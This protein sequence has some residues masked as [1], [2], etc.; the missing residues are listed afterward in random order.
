MTTSS[1]L[2]PTI[3]S[4]SI[5]PL[6]ASRLLSTTNP[7]PAQV[8][9]RAPPR[10]PRNSIRGRL[11]KWEEENPAPTFQVPTDDSPDTSVGN[12]ITKNTSELNFRLDVPQDED[13]RTPQ[14][15][16][17]DIIDLGS[18]GAVLQP[19][20]LVELRAST[21][22]LRLLAICLGL[23]NGHWHFYT[24]T[25][26]W[27]TTRDMRFG[28]VVRG[29]VQ[30][31]AELRAVIDAIPSTSSSTAVLNELQELNIGPSRD[32]AASLLRRMYA[33]QL[34]A[35][36]IHQSYVERLSRPHL[37]LGDGERLLSLREIADALLPSSLKRNQ[38]VFPPEALYAVYSVIEQDDVAFRS[39]D[40]TARVNEAFL[41]HFYSSRVQRSVYEVEEMVRNYFESKRS[42]SKSQTKTQANS[43]AQLDRFLKAA[44]EVID[45]TRKTRKWSPHG[46]IGTCSSEPSSG[47]SSSPIPA[48][49]SDAGMTIIEFMHHWAASGGF[50]PGSRCHAIGA[51]VLRALERYDDVL[52]DTTTGWTF[53]QEIGWIAPWDVAARHRLRIPGI[54]LDRHP[55]LPAPPVSQEQAKKLA[56]GEDRLAGLRQ[57]FARSSVFCIDSADT[58]DVDD[59]VSLEPGP[60]SG[61]HWVNVHVA[62]P[63]SRITPDHPL[64]V[65]AAMRAQTS[66]LAGWYQRM[67]DS[68]EV[69][70]TFSLRANAP[71]LTFSALVD[72]EGKIH[73]FKI[74]PG[75]LR[76]VVYMSYEEVSQLFDEE[77][78]PTQVPSYELTVGTPPQPS[79]PTRPLASVRDLSRAQRS[80]L[81][82]LHRLAKALQ[83]VRLSKG[84]VPTY[85]PQPQATVRLDAVE[86]TL[87]E[88]NSPKAGDNPGLVLYRGD[89]YIRVAY[90][91]QQSPA[92]TLVSSMMQLAGE[93]G[94]RWCYERDIPVPYRVQLL[95]TQN[96]EALKN[97]T[98]N[99]L[100]PKLRAGIK[101][102]LEDFHTLR[103]LVG[104][105]EL[106]TTPTPNYLM[107]L[108]M[109]TKVTS[110]LRRYPDLLV[111]WQIEAA[112]LEEA[113][114]GKSLAVRNSLN[115]DNPPPQA[116]PSQKPDK[117]FLPFSKPD[118]DRR[119]LPRLRA[120]E[121]H[122]RLTDNVDGNSQWILQALV[123]AHFFGENPEQV[124]KTFRFT[125]LDTLGR[126]AMFGRLNYFD[127]SAVVELADFNNVIRI[128][129]VK[130]GMVFE[131]ELVRVNVHRGRV[132]VRL[133]RKIGQE[134][135][136]DIRI[137][138]DQIKPVET[139]L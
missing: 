124:P 136:E 74:T 33:F 8:Q 48:L 80:D 138:V 96:Q 98:E 17:D 67:I 23:F 30:D 111:H 24:S 51:S 40:R 68:D 18:V 81:L 120:R 82:T 97:F 88:A 29:F 10:F 28:F 36:E 1:S 100:Y 125:T 121:R 79:P 94:A 115:P 139:S 62:D 21:T 119:I 90:Q 91:S 4:T 53:L 110:P 7:V 22:R 131:V 35:R 87:L 107:G 59:G 64:A 78:T 65:Q 95:A 117:S 112:L 3:V 105:Y 20:D 73:D 77:S 72:E 56:L 31:P 14:F 122:G 104:G 49:W 52:Y 101:P 103:T 85:L 89:P 45:K 15:D 47:S 116:D 26:K 41:Y 128:G 57:E 135:R 11:Q 113:R 75:I 50:R 76:D 58:L 34:K 92:S 83:N 123:R 38:G 12:I 19:G 43:A 102:T 61:Q 132:Y 129:E 69:R 32:L 127:L 106:S 84:A 134:E 126:A 108:D 42:G 6:P 44:R 9:E 137:R 99:V 130:S 86:H 55:A 114:L 133:L 71:T 46:M 66:Y 37:L 5:L 60:V 118:L 16:P 109:Y 27:L 93:I 54:T 13:V 2:R 70:E 63:A 25:G 39:L